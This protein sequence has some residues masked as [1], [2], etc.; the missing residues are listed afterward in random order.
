[1]KHM[2]RLTVFV[3]G[4]GSN[5]QAIHTAVSQRRLHAEIVGVVSN[6]SASPALEFAHT[7]RISRLSLEDMETQQQGDEILAFL[8]Q[9]RTDFIALAGYMKLIPS[10][11]VAAFRHRIT[12]IHP[13]LL[14]SFGGKGMYGRHVHEAVLSSG[15]KVS[16][17]TVHL[18]D[19]EYDRGPI[20]MQ[21]CV[22]VLD[23]DTPESLATRVLAV[24][25]AMYPEA[26]QLFAEKRVELRG[27]RIITRS[28]RIL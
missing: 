27:N 16:G 6:R 3:S 23:D 1:M 14:P 20:V 4:R 28:L 8:E 15:V 21:R 18:V 10:E 25:H 22:P 7:Q 12:N 5:L 24:E 17:A 19:E 11:V 13:A 9:T 26:L 2:L